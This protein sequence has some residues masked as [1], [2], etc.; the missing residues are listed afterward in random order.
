MKLTKRVLIIIA[1]FM[2]TC[3]MNACSGGDG[4]GG[5]A[6]G[7]SLYDAGAPVSAKGFEETYPIELLMQ[8]SSGDFAVVS[9]G[10]YV[11]AGT[12]RFAVR[13]QGDDATVDRVFLSDGGMYQVEALKDGD[14][15]YCD[16]VIKDDR[17]YEDV[18]IQVIHT[19]ERASKEKIVFRTS[20]SESQ[21]TLILNGIG[22]MVSQ[23]LLDGSRDQIAEFI[24]AMLGG[25]FECIEGQD[26]GLITRIN[27]GDDNPNTVDVQVDT[28]EA[29]Q[30]DAWPTAVLHLGLTIDDVDLSAVNLYGQDFISTSDNDLVLDMYVALQDVREDG[31]RGLV[32][33]LLDS[34]EV[35]FVNDFF[36]RPV[37][38]EMIAS[39]L[40][41]IERT[42]LVADLQYLTDTL[43]DAMPLTITVGDTEVDLDVLFEDLNVD[44]SKYL[45]VDLYGIPEYT[46]TG[47]LALGAGIYGA[48]YEDAGEEGGSDP[49]VS[50]FDPEDVFT[51][52]CATVADETFSK[53]K[54][55]Y[56][57]IVTT[58]S[59]G[60]DD[61]G[62]DDLVIN[63]LTVQSTGNANIKT[64]RADFTIRD[65]DLKAVSLFGF[66]LISTS[67]NDLTI[68]ATFQVTYERSGGADRI[69]LDVQSASSA[70][71][72][73]IFLGDLVVEELVRKDV[74]DL[75]NITFNIDEFL[76]DIEMDIDLTDC[77]GE[78]P[79]F[80]DVLEAYSPY[81]WDLA[82]L[83]ENNLSIAISQDTVN[84][85]LAQLVEPGFEWDVYEILRPI[86]GDDF[87]G[88]QVDQQEGEETILRLSV[89]P[90]LDL[91]ANR[92][93]MELDDVVLE[94]RLNDQPQWMASIDLDLILTVQ[95]E[96][97]NLAFYLSTAPENC[98]FHIM[99]DNPG[100]LGVFDHSNLVNDIVERL[101]ELFGNQEGGPVF[102]VALDSFE[103]FLE[104]EDTSS[105]LWVTANQG[106]LYV[107]AAASAMDLSWLL[108]V[109]SS[110]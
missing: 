92:I 41:V 107:D 74:E 60:D 57:G 28:L 101:P 9:D 73:D 45:F 54:D 2:I 34:T 56:D 82:L 105:P 75:E 48:D 40:H 81:T 102:T 38:E 31:T 50:A 99:R 86:L 19:D 29:V 11:Q 58:L 14:L 108:E 63:S 85:I 100:N 12:K 42:P 24:D 7:E 87:A 77:E 104:L 18:L 1:V 52:L 36:M 84:G 37:V 67:N 33:D 110:N 8:D 70:D 80:P 39:S 94:Y 49:D 59:F 10:Q 55:E 20:E 72:E 97:N 88:F 6:E 98:H 4:S 71:F 96:G 64:V 27:Y 68:D 79:L 66:S 23:D 32:L 89:P 43:H 93:R 30:D 5:S 15:Y 91:R 21:D 17:L 83:L 62:T 61:P 22:V 106:Y 53:I 13:I 26:S 44:L 90:V 51:D 3:F 65:V 78:G 46:S 103:P 95:V 47:A 35:Y 69:V 109:F 76:E 25:I 16:F